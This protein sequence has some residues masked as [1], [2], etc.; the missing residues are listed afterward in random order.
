MDRHHGL[1]D[2]QRF[3]PGKWC[4]QRRRIPLDSKLCQ[5]G[6]VAADL[7]C[8]CGAEAAKPC[9][10]WGFVHVESGG[11]GRCRQTNIEHLHLEWQPNNV[12]AITNNNHAM[13]NA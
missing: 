7:K 13:T 11:F 6:E 3:A 12:A 8:A 4:W 1:G 2:E 9:Q 10:V 5:V